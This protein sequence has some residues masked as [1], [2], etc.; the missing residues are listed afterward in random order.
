MVADTGPGGPGRRLARRFLAPP[1]RALRRFLGAEIQIT[2]RQISHQLS[3]LGPGFAAPAGAAVAGPAAGPLRRAVHQFHAGTA[4]ADA[5]TNALFFTRALLRDLG[6]RS[7]IYAEHPD[8]RLGPAIRPLEELP[9]H[10]GYVLLLHHSMGHG[11][12][13]E[14]RTLPC[15]KVLIYH[16]ITPAELFAHGAS[17]EAARQGRADLGA[18]SALVAAALAVSDFNA[19][20]L[21]ARGFAPV[22]V[23]PLLFDLAALEARAAAAPPR[24]PA[25]PFTILFVGRIAAAKG[26]ADLVEAFARFRHRFARPCRLVLLGRTDP[27][28]AACAAAIAASIR[29]HGLADAVLLPGAVSDAE[30]D[31]WYASAHLYVSLSRHEGVGLPLLEALAFGLPLLA[32]PAGAVPYTLGGAGRLLGEPT[33]EAAARAMLEIAADPAAAADPG[34]ARAALASHSR[35]NLLPALREALAHAGAA[36]PR[37]PAAH[38]ALAAHLAITLAGHV[39]GAYSLAAVNRTLARALNAAR[40]GLVRLRPVEGEPTEDTDAIPPEERAA[41]APLIARPAPASGPEVVISQHW[42]PWPP[43][44]PG[45]LPL[46]LLF[47]EETLLPPAVVGALARSFRAVLAPSRAT[48]RALADSGLALP[49]LTV[50]HVP[51]L[52]DFL[53]LPDH[54]APGAA[55]GGRFCFLHVSSG[56]PR[57][58]T[59]LL[60]AAFARVFRATDPVRLVLKTAPNPHQHLAA[61]LAARRA[62][63]PAGPEIVLI[64]RDLPR[65]EL[66]ALYAAADAVVLPTRGEGFNLPAAEAMAAGLPLIVTAAGGHRDFCG[67]GEARLLRYR[68]RPSRSHL[69]TG[70]S[71][72]AEPDADD[73]AAALGEAVAPAPDPVI[74]ARAAAARAR[75]RALADAPAHAARLAGA[76]ASLL[77]APPPAAL[78]LAFVATFAVPCGVAEYSR[79][80]LDALLAGAAPGAI[81]ATLLCDDRTSPAEPAPGDAALRPCW[82][83]GDPAA[84]GPIALAIAREDPE[85][86]VIQHQSGLLPWAALGE[87]LADPRLAGRIV[88][89]ALHNPRDLL[90]LAPRARAH[91]LAA[92]GRAER[93]LVHTLADLDLLQDLGLAENCSLLP[94]GAPAPAPAAVARPLPPGSDPV[95]GCHGFFL[96]HKGIGDLIAAGARLRPRWPGLR[97][98]LVNAEYPLAQGGAASGDE[99]AACRALAASLGVADMVEWETSFLPAARAGELLRG[100]D[101]LVLPYRES[102]ESSS[103]AVRA[104]L[105]TGVPVALTRVAIFADAAAAAAPLTASDPVAMAA[106]IAALLADPA[107]RAGLAAAARGWLADHAWPAIAG[108][109]R[110]LLFSLAATARIDPPAWPPR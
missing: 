27:D 18:L 17:A 26:Q 86:V 73:L 98:R 28:E 64:E 21:R 37:D 39:N 77:L 87:L 8:P 41:L 90:T 45:D 51:E 85:A 23:C 60:L 12:L 78:R 59:D 70:H 68:M 67:P 74:A 110:G 103:A 96:P 15:P 44:R 25:A 22:G 56:L 65:A 105:A 61:D 58:G 9:R 104:V 40:P 109:L 53:A 48:A 95:I 4:P 11:A 19:I 75:A 42:P 34:A 88:L 29:H 24:D 30:R 82:R 79:A 38:A 13:A 72:W 102:A 76:C 94:Q 106:E 35:A 16:N 20:E 49:V 55:R 93:L 6:Y 54:P 69:A 3:L 71:L 33:P 43:D 99:I 92:L 7:E 97:L 62:A 66:L 83:V 46:A 10:D 107:A 91:V 84:A 1:A 108:R 57:K 14:L 81:R 5:V 80:L 50:G 100:C 89:V 2:L 36:P 31:R 63:D 47:W 101:L 52:A 32:W